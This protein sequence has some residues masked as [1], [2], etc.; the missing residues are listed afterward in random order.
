MQCNSKYMAYNYK[1][2]PVLM[3]HWPSKSTEFAPPKI[4][5]ASCGRSSSPNSLTVHLNSC[6][7]FIFLRTIV[8]IVEDSPR[9]ASPDP[10]KPGPADP[11]FLHQ[12][13]SL[14]GV[15][16]GW[17]GDTDT[18]AHT[19]GRADMLCSSDCRFPSSNKNCATTISGINWY[20]NEM[21]RSSFHWMTK[22]Y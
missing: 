5:L 22:L 17:W 10:A 4:S 16:R 11:E 19:R 2:L 6:Y 21:K 7:I 20:T 9:R 3:V 15:G 13:D 8:T 18:V 12:P 1:G 14:V